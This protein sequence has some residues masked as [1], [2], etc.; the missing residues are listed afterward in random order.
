MQGNAFLDNCFFVCAVNKKAV[1]GSV[2][3][4]CVCGKADD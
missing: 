4:K 1:R 3:R 2:Y